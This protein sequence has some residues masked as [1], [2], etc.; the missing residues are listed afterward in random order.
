ML[1]PLCLAELE[2]IEQAG[3][4]LPRAAAQ[5]SLFGERTEKP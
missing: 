2:R 4:P 3:E 5:G 1:L